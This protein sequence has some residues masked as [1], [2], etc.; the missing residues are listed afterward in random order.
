MRKI[1]KLIVLGCVLLLA[2]VSRAQ[3]QKEASGFPAPIEGWERVVVDFPQSKKGDH[4]QRF[5]FSIGFEMMVD[6][7]NTYSLIGEWKEMVVEDS[8]YFMAQTKGQVVKTMIACD[9]SKKTSKFVGLDSKWYGNEDGRP[10]VVYVPSG[11]Q[12]RYRIW[13]VDDKWYTYVPKKEVIKAK[14]KVLH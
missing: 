11:Y 10:L 5:E 9:H 7:C 14:K 12:L 2:G 3:E 4:T 13:T 1:R 6:A 8:V